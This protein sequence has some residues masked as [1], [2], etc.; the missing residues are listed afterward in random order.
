MAEFIPDIYH[1]CH[2]KKDSKGGG[3]G[4]HSVN[5][6]AKFSGKLT[7][8]TPS[9]R[10]F[11]F[12]GNFVYVLNEWSLSFFWWDVYFLIHSHLTK[13]L[14][15]CSFYGRVA[16]KMF[17]NQKRIV[18][19]GVSSR[20]SLNSYCNLLKKDDEFCYELN[21][22]LFDIHVLNMLYIKCNC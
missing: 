12:L 21:F 2:L 9:Y 16:Q 19:S 13:Y 15:L 10:T 14:K 8:L 5:T 1:W 20:V 11:N 4:G 3:G 18:V 7:F 6:Y 22:P 17:F